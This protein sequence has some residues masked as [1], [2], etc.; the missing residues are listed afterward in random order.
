LWKLKIFCI[1]KA[2]EGK[3]VLQTLR[4]YLVSKRVTRVTRQREGETA[5]I[6]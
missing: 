5:L 4:E 2:T 1:K 3:E 6:E